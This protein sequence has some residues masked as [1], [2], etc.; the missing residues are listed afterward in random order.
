MHLSRV[1]RQVNRVPR[2][3]AAACYDELSARMQATRDRLARGRPYPVLD[4]LRELDLA[5]ARREV[6][7]LLRERPPARRAPRHRR[8]S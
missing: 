1:R 8:G 7:T 3:A 5:D 6:E 4:R 2:T